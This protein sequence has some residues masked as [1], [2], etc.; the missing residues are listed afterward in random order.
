MDFADLDT[1]QATC[2]QFVSAD[3]KSG[4][5]FAVNSDPEAQGGCKVKIV[6]AEKLK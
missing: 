4:I 3:S 1:W 2:S 6:I 5:I